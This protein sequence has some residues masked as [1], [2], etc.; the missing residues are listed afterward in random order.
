MDNVQSEVLIQEGAGLAD[1]LGN[2]DPNAN[3]GAEPN[4]NLNLTLTSQSNPRP[5]KKG[6]VAKDDSSRQKSKIPALCLTPTAEQFLKSPN[7]K[8]TSTLN[9]KTHSNIALSPKTLQL[10]VTPDF[11]SQKEDSNRPKSVNQTP[12]STKAQKQDPARQESRTH[13]SETT[14][15]QTYP[16]PS[17]QRNSSGTRSRNTSGSKE[18]PEG[19]DSS[20]GSRS[21]TSSNASPDP[22]TATGPKESLG[23]KSR[24]ASKTSLGSK[25]SLD[26][27]TGIN[28]KASPLCKSGTG[29]R[30]SLDFKTAT[31]IKVSKNS[32]D[33][34]RDVGLKSGM[35]SK[36][37]LD[38]KNPSNSQASSRLKPGPTRST[39]KPSLVAS[40]SKTDLVESAT[41]LSSRTGP[42]DLKLNEASSSAKTTPDPKAGFDYSNSGPV[43]SSS[44]L[45]LADWSPSSSLPPRPSPGNRSPAY[46][47]GKTL[48]SSPTGPTREVLKSPGSAQGLMAPLATSSPKIRTT[49]SLTMTRASAPCVTVETNTSKTS[50][51][52]SLSR[53][54][55][56]D[57]ITKTS[58]RHV[59]NEE[60]VDVMIHSPPPSHLGDKNTNNAGGK[61]LPSRGE[62][63]RKQEKGEE[64]DGTTSTLHL[65]PP[66]RSLRE[67]ATMTDPSLGLH[68]WGGERRDVGVQVEVERLTFNDS[69]LQMGVP[70]SSGLISPT[71]VQHICKIDIELSSQSVSESVETDRAS[72]LP[73]C[74]RT[75]SFQENPEI[76]SELRLGQ[77]QGVSVASFWEE[78]VGREKTEVEVDVEEQEQE[79]VG[80]PQKVVWDDQGRTWE[81]YG[82]SVDLESLGTAIQS[83]LESKIR[84]QQKHIR[85]LRQSV[86]SDSSLRAYR[87]RKRRKRRAGILGCCRKT[88]N[89]VSDEEEEEEEGR[90]AGMLQEDAQLM[91]EMLVV[92]VEDKDIA[93]V[94][95]SEMMKYTTTVNIYPRVSAM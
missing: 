76:T 15:S 84:E 66:V 44:K 29:S 54:L 37:N 90:D 51:Y 21:K 28:S 9:P 35:G 62:E 1:A 48:G 69:S 59:D 33:S 83:H 89:S 60:R 49:V 16:K 5:S 68:S 65:L 86:C 30:D 18:K 42:K 4:F 85:T 72:S 19:K 92:M 73:A 34:N 43:R 24:S 2:T 36:D 25:D 87:M 14:K 47:S 56:F 13:S 58:T 61:T 67:K 71:M 82:A 45:A 20:V 8:C 10:P 70:S 39:S 91:K 78:E 23:S 41:H 77:N 74:L 50:H 27:K 55:T 53:G 64:K 63:S 81:V 17:T 38:L 46:G 95:F 6:G 22:K 3:L 93:K 94:V 80:R 11:H 79:D 52:T 57:S 88:P 40:G 31:E 12:I 26:S 32:P 75:Y 7:P